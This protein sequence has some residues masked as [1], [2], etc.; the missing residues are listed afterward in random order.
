MKV[1]FITKRRI[2]GNR[3][4]LVSRVNTRG[5]GVVGGVVP[6]I[7]DFLVRTGQESSNRPSSEGVALVSKPSLGADESKRLNDAMALQLGDRIDRIEKMEQHFRPDGTIVVVLG[8]KK[9]ELY[10]QGSEFTALYHQEYNA[11]PPERLRKKTQ[12]YDP[13]MLAQA[14][15]AFVLKTGKEVPTQTDLETFSGTK[16]ETW[17][18]Y[19]SKPEIWENVMKRLES[20]WNVH[21]HAK[22]NLEQARNN[23]AKN[24]RSKRSAEDATTNSAGDPGFYSA[25]SANDEESQ[26]HEK[27]DEIIALERLGK[28]KLVRR[29]L[30]ADP[31]YSKS[32]LDEVSGSELAALVYDLD[33]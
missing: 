12:K 21:S 23:Q 33:A 8:L 13:E 1:T 17:S 6:V 15:L 26:I 4:K 29:L 14:Y 16:Q 3:L 2:Q 25:E 5:Y 7:L 11:D 22:Q 10:R 27:L 9:E 20:L 18:R 31:K 32:E 28:A 24:R 30:A 19:L